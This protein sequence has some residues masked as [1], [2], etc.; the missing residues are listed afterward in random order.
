[1]D[2]DN[3]T[4][5]NSIDPEPIVN[6]EGEVRWIIDDISEP[7][8][9]VDK[10]FAVRKILWELPELKTFEQ[11]DM[12]EVYNNMLEI[13]KKVLG[14]S[15]EIE[16]KIFNLWIIS[17][18]KQECWDTVGFPVF[19]GPYNS[20]KSTCL[21]TIAQ[22][23]YRI[24]KS[25]NPTFAVMPRLTHYHRG[26]LLIDEAHD[27]LNPGTNSQKLGFIKDS[28]KRGSTYLSCDNNNQKGVVATKNL[29]KKVL[30][31]QRILDLRLLLEK[32]VLILRC[33]HVP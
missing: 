20:G 33:S 31:Q 6:S 24:V 22:M 18:W 10:E 25:I 26:A 12:H 1:L 3:S 23:G 29:I 21:Q 5:I 27:S 4:T 7:V 28:Y 9:V 15:E 32:R 17:T 2:N 11:L 16:Y 19:I 30:W 13:S 8:T 14:F